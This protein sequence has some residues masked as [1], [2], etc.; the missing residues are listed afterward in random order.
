VLLGRI[1]WTDLLVHDL[2]A[3][4]RLT[5][6]PMIAGEGTPIFAGQ[7]SVTGKLLSRRAWQSPG[8]ALA[9]YQVGGE[10]H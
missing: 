9:C 7:P 4:P 5:I 6:S 8:N 1:L 10:R 2:V 3:E